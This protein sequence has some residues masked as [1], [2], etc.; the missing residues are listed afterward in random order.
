MKVVTFKGIEKALIV[1]PVH[2]VF[3]LANKQLENPKLTSFLFFKKKNHLGLLGGPVVKNWATNA[4][5]A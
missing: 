1:C 3:V 4:G 5:G 2:L